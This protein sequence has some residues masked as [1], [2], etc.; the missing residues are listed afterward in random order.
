MLDIERG[1]VVRTW[2]PDGRDVRNLVLQVFKDYATVVPVFDREIPDNGFRIA[3]KL[4]VDVSKPKPLT[5]KMATGYE[6]T[7]HLNDD[8]TN[9]IAFHV[10]RVIGAYEKEADQESCNERAD[11]YT[12]YSFAVDKLKHELDV[13]KKEGTEVKDELVQMKTSLIQ[14]M[15]ERDVFERLYRELL[16]STIG[17]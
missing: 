7:Q 15:A 14:A 17:K 16:T 12:D 2:L 8:V 3:E 6:L 4:F 5:S 11:I 13:A 9:E 10:G 1:D